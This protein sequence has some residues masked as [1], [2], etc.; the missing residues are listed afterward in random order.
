MRDESVSSALMI[1]IK[2]RALFT[3]RISIHDWSLRRQYLVVLLRVAHYRVVTKVER[4]RTPTSIV[5][6][7]DRQYFIQYIEAMDVYILNKNAENLSQAQGIFGCN[8]Q[9]LTDVMS[10]SAN[11][12]E[13]FVRCTQSPQNQ[14]IGDIMQTNPCFYFAFH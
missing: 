4:E 3:V 9:K 5:Y 10:I 11:Q 1:E 8:S 13:D 14:Y 2:S 7:L 12:I 6:Y